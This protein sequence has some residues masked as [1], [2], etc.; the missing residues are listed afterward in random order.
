VLH[1]VYD[2]D[3]EA[4][5]TELGISRTASKVRLHRARRKLHDLLFV[6]LSERDELVMD[7]ESAPVISLPLQASG[8]HR[9]VQDQRS[10]VRGDHA[11]AL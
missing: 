8:R 10:F 6:P 5:A 11:D 9:T 4:I 1:D 2:L 7:R 3:H